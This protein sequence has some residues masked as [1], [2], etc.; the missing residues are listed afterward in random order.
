MC[1]L[2]SLLLSVPAGGEARP[3]PGEPA[4]V[5]V[6]NTVASGCSDA[7]TGTQ[8]TPYCTIRAALAVARPG[9]TIRV[10]GRFAEHVTI[11][12]SGAPGQPITLRGVAGPDG[13]TPRLAGPNA[14]LT[15]SGV[16][17]VEVDDL[18]VDMP[19]TGSA[20]LDLHDS[21]RLTMRRIRVAQ[22]PQTGYPELGAAAVFL[23]A[24]TDSE[25]LELSVR[26]HTKSMIVMVGQTSRTH[27]TTF[28]RKSAGGLG[29]SLM[30]VGDDN[31]VTGVAAGVAGLPNSTQPC[32]D[33]R[34]TARQDLILQLLRGDCLL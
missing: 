3:D 25:L 6:D 21:I 9:L 15:I 12:R 20:G 10:R 24:V 4:P 23:R 31:T 18:Q 14:G 16:H 1:L 33:L 29:G 2:L 7:G 19:A 17:D 13:A 32:A 26:V 27:V 8:A 34:A 5:F 22:Q 11:D 28:S 30:I